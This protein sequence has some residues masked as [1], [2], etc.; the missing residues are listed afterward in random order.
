MDKDAA[1]AIERATD[2]AILYKRVSLQTLSLCKLYAYSIQLAQ[3]IAVEIILRFH[4]STIM[5][6]LCLALLRCGLCWQPEV[7]CLNEIHYLFTS[8][9]LTLTSTIATS[10]TV[11][12][13]HCAYLHE[14][15]LG[16]PSM[17]C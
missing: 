17:A 2:H 6:K 5:S 4:L 10:S 14:S 11:P 8:N 16:F 9:Y 7:G 13:M 12:G 15:V 3:L 1:A